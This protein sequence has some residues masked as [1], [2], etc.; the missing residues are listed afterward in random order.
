MGPG[1]VYLVQGV[2][3]CLEVKLVQ[4]GGC[5]LLIAVSTKCVFPFHGEE[6]EHSRCCRCLQVLVPGLDPVYLWG[7]VS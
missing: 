4:C 3:L 5:G 2:N 7:L 1:R 6:P